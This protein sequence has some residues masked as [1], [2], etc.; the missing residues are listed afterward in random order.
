MKRILIKIFGSK[1]ADFFVKFSSLDVDHSREFLSEHVL[2]FRFGPFL[3]SGLNIF[4]F[5]SLSGKFSWFGSISILFKILRQLFLKLL[6]SLIKLF[7]S[8]L[9]YNRQRDNK[10]TNCFL[11]FLLKTFI[12]SILLTSSLFWGLNMGFLLSFLRIHMKIKA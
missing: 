8:N 6:H 12:D 2:F 7:H 10:A 9:L 3:N 11:C 1:I 4:F 5:H